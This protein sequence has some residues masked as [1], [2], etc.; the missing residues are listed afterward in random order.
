M[1][2][3]APRISRWV[4]HV[5]NRGD[6]R[7]EIFR[8]DPDRDRFLSTLT[9]ACGKTEWQVHA[10]P[11]QGYGKTENG[12]LSSEFKPV[13]RVWGLSGEEFRRMCLASGVRPSS[14]AATFA[15]L[16]RAG[17]HKPK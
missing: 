10:Y 7:E 2:Q 9:A 15:L 8:D 12:G 13:E 3:P 4:Y 16:Q 14:A 11:I 17:A 5:V 6:R 1:P